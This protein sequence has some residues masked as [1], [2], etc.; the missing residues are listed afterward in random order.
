MQA[1]ARRLPV[2]SATPC[3][4]R[5]LIRDVRPKKKASPV[6]APDTC[7]SSRTLL[8]GFLRLWLTTAAS[9]SIF[10][11]VL[12][13]LQIAGFSAFRGFN[14][15]GALLLLMFLGSMTLPFTMIIALAYVAIP[16]SFV[17]LSHHRL[18]SLDRRLFCLIV[19]IASLTLSLLIVWASPGH[20]IGFGGRPEIATSFVGAFSLGM[21]VGTWLHF[22]SSTTGRL[23]SCS[24]HQ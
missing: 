7:S 17:I 4:R 5:R 6:I 8:S 14:E 18:P 19:F 9:A 2:V 24:K 16:C 11:L 20:V 22:R 13:S 21:L 23:L 12:V 3:A 10:G 1:T 15:F